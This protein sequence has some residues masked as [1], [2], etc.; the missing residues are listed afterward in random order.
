[1]S[2]SGE[3]P[4]KFK[5]CSCAK[6]DFQFHAHELLMLGVSPDTEVKHDTIDTFLKG[7]VRRKERN[8]KIAEIPPGSDL[9]QKLSVLP[10][11]LNVN[12]ETMFVRIREIVDKTLPSLE[13]LSCVMKLLEEQALLYE[14]EVVQLQ[15]KI[16]KFE[17]SA[18]L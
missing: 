5:G 6:G 11:F 15:A 17:A 10:L 2:G 9:S 16:Q 1:M 3:H 7:V 13:A 14:H 12:P 4:K 8:Y 18:I